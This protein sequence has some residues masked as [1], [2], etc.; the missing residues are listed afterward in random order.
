MSWNLHAQSC[1]I[2]LAEVKS[3][4]EFDAL[5]SSL[6]FQIWKECICDDCIPDHFGC[7]DIPLDEVQG[8]SFILDGLKQYIIEFNCNEEGVSF[9]VYSEYDVQ[10]CGDMELSERISEF[11]L[12][13]S[14]IPYCLTQSSAFDNSGG[15]AHQWITFKDGDQVRS[16]SSQS[17]IDSLLKTNNYSFSMV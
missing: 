4:A 5:L 1:C 13:N 14:S 11:F 7:D 9:V 2:K 8:V 17:F 16:M 10:E 12:L 3:N 6:A 15:Y